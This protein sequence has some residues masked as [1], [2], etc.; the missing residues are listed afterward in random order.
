LT[1]LSFMQDGGNPRVLEDKL[2]IYLDPVAR[3]KLA[4]G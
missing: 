2:S 3:A 1:A 4:K